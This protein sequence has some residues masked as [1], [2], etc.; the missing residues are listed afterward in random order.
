MILRQSLTL[1]RVQ[2][3]FFA[4]VSVLQVSIHLASVRLASYSS[5]D[6]FSSECLLSNSP[7]HL[8]FLQLSSGQLLLIL[9]LLVPKNGLHLRSELS[10]RAYQAAEPNRQATRPE[11]F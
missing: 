5:A 8:N 7:A 10:V 2:A 4:P 11:L 9:Y 1:Q 3:V 6:P